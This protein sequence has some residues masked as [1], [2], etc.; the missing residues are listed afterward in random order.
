MKKIR[1]N[2]WIA[3]NFLWKGF[4]TITLAAWVCTKCKSK[5]EMPQSLRNHECVHARQ[6]VEIAF[7][8]GAVIWALTLFMDISP[9]WYLLAFIGF[10]ILYVI[11]Y[12]ILLIKYGKKA[13]KYIS[14]EIE[15]R[16]SEQDSNYLENGDYFEWVRYLLKK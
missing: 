1:Y 16:I 2:S 5:E 4:G 12:L 6:W 11:E 14:F 7:V 3:N 10:Y 8:M 15:A 13:Y 9:W